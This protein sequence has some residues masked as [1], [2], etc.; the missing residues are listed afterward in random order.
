MLGQVGDYQIFSDMQVALSWKL[1][2]HSNLQSVMRKRKWH[3]SSILQIVAIA[4]P[5]H[6]TAAGNHNLN[7]CHQRK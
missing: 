3:L 6:T 7:C 2:G 1:W 4:I 5:L